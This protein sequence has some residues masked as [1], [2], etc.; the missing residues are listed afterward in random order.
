LAWVL[1]QG[2]GL[3]TGDEGLQ[4]YARPFLDPQMMNIG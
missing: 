1:A 3:P 2:D 4:G